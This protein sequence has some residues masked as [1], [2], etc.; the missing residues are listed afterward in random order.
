[1]SNVSF[2]G[3]IFWTIPIIQHEHIMIQRTC[4]QQATNMLSDHAQ[5][6]EWK[7]ILCLMVLQIYLDKILMLHVSFLKAG[8]GRIRNF[9]NL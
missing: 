9:F 4:P 8:K 5:Y 7:L 1:M 2:A 6:H 3:F